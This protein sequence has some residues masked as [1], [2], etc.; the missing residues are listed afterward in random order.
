MTTPTDTGSQLLAAI[1]AEPAEDTPRLVYADWLDENGHA[2]RAA[3]IRGSIMHS[4]TVLFFDREPPWAV[5]PDGVTPTWSRGFVSAVT[6]TAA[7][8]LGGEC[9]R[10]GGRGWHDT[11]PGDAEMNCLACNG[12][13]RT[14]GLAKELFAAHPIERVT[15]SD[16]RPLQTDDAFGRGHPAFV[17][18]SGPA[19]AA[20]SPH[21]LPDSLVYGCRAFYPTRDAALAA[22]S[23][24]CV[25]HG[26]KLAGLP[27]LPPGSPT[28]CDKV[29]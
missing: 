7:A 23:A 22:L 29:P 20:T 26:R 18:F 10:C 25:R 27:P 24:A 6:L 13:G 12:T 5:L 17:W 11:N 28:G 16:K 15:L 1:L 2:S 14:P 9:Q 19:L 21:H 3:Y 4:E 8:Y